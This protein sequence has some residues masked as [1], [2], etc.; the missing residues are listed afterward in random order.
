MFLNAYC[1]YRHKNFIF[2]LTNLNNFTLN[3]HISNK[4]D[5]KLLLEIMCLS[6][7]FLK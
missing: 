7:L 2:I 6:L 5:E 4:I 1:K 3:T